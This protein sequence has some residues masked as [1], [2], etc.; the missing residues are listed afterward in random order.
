MKKWQIILTVVIVILA[1]AGFFFW[2][3]T[4]IYSAQAVT[5]VSGSTIGIAPFTDR[6]DFGD[7]PQGDT[8][9]KTVTL[10]NSGNNSNSI[11]I[12]ILGSI[13][14]MITVTPG[15]SFAIGAGESQDINFQLAMPASAAVG[16]KFTGRI[17]ILKLP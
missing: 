8:I 2:R 14:Q 5:V 1:I 16:K 3:S 10:T 15:K 11:K 4:T 6:V 17:I 9:S 7:I 13:S 12:Y